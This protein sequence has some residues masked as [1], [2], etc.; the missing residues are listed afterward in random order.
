MP[1]VQGGYRRWLGRA[2]E[3]AGI[4]LPAGQCSHALRHHCVSVL[5]DRGFSD[6]AIGE[7]IGDTAQTIAQTYGRPMP[8]TLDRMAAVLD[9]AHTA[10]RLRVVGDHA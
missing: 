3:R 7:W 1:Y 10:P 6:Q 8:D 4:D 9:E 2:A 5:R